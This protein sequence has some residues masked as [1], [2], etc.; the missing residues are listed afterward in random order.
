MTTEEKIDYILDIFN[1]PNIS[2]LGIATTSPNLL[3]FNFNI[4]SFEEYLSDA[5][6]SL[7]DLEEAFYIISTL[8]G[9]DVEDLRANSHKLNIKH[10]D[11][12]FLHMVKQTKS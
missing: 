11:L 1:N 3:V 10:P 8:G 12:L 4:N 6:V 5:T 9:A 7:V 2:I